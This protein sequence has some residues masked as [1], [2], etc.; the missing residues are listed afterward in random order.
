VRL[1]EIP[2]FAFSDSLP[3]FVQNENT[4]RATDTTVSAASECV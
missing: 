3:G 1:R 4:E 2:V